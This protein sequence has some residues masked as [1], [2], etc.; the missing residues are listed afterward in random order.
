MCITLWTAPAHAGAPTPFPLLFVTQVPLRTDVAARLSAFANHLTGVQQVPR[1]GDLMLRYPDGSLRALTRE[2]GY[3]NRGQQGLGAIAVREPAVHPSGTRAVFSMLVGSPTGAGQPLPRWQMYEVRGLQRGAR[4]VI[5]KIPGQPAYNNVSPLYG[6]DDQILF[7]SDS[8]RDGAP[9]L[10]PALDEY[11][12]TP[13]TTGIWKLDPASGRLRILNHAVSGAFTPILDSAGRVVFTRWDHQQQDQLAQRDRDAARNGVAVP[14]KSMNYAGEAAGAR[15][16][17][18]RDEAF[19]ESR[20]GSSSPYGQVSAFATNF[21][22]LWQMEEDGR[23]EETVNHIGQHELAF[24][25]LTPTFKDDPALCMI[26]VVAVTAFAMKGDEERIR[27]GGCEAYLSKPIS[28]GKF[29]ETVRR[30]IG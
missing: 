21:F 15:V 4:A 27:E 17:A 1:G 2:A 19:P 29:I 10:Y 3:G 30:F 25:F 16:L 9:H 6:S 12:A 5:R 23:N 28:V 26:P 7:T 22:T 13:T 18:G 20:S 11:E 24:G 14:F 8:P